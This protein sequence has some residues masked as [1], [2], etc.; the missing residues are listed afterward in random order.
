MEGWVASNVACMMLSYVQCSW[1]LHLACICKSFRVT[2]AS[3]CFRATLV[4]VPITL[5][6]YYY[7]LAAHSLGP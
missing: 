4:S 7:K 5:P 2:L 3:R 1:L 6:K